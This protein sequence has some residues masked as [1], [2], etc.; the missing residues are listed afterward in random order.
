MLTYFI[1]GALIVALVA[2][3]TFYVWKRRVDKNTQRPDEMSPTARQSRRRTTGM[4]K[5]SVEE[6]R[7]SQKEQV[8]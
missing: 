5:G 1:W 6:A 3:A 7:P 4:F 2:A 8:D